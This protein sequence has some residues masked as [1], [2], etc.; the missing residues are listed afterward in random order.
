MAQRNTRIT[1]IQMF[2]PLASYISKRPHGQLLRMLACSKRAS[3][4]PAPEGR[5]E[6]SVRARSLSHIKLRPGSGG[7][8]QHPARSKTKSVVHR[9]RLETINVN[10]IHY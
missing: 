5:A 8:A 1:R 10:N 2:P 7:I 3:P 9:G 4:A 6:P